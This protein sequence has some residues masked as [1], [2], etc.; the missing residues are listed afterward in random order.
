MDSDAGVDASSKIIAAMVT[1][2]WKPDLNY[3][4]SFREDFGVT[5]AGENGA[6]QQWSNLSGNLVKPC[7]SCA[8]R[9]KTVLDGT[10]GGT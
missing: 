1:M 2:E 4:S 6:Y 8:I 3:V 9:M 7:E 5:R 10:A